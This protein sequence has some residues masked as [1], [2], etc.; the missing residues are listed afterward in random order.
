MVKDIKLKE[1]SKRK[2][3]ESGSRPLLAG[4]GLGTRILIPGP[5]WD[6]R[7]R[8]RVRVLTLKHG[9]FGLFTDFS[10]LDLY[11]KRYA[12]MCVCVSA[13]VKIWVKKRKIDGSASLLF[14]LRSSFLHE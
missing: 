4:Y 11:L 1:K 2:K 7:L 9:L 10:G 14:R 13:S 12:R 6:P 3:K 5:D 8:I